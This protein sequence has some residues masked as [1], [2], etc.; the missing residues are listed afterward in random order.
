MN[1]TFLI[2]RNQI[3]PIPAW[4]VA[5]AAGVIILLGAT[6]LICLW[7]LWRGRWPQFSLRALFVVL[8]V[9]AVLTG[10]AVYAG[11]DAFSHGFYITWN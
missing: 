4:L 2:T 7:R 3:G 6:F 11:R 1:P 9:L 10:W 5:V 8:T